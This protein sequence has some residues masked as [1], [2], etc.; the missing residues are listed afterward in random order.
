MKKRIPSFFSGF[1]TA[2]L[3]LALTTTALAASGKVRYNFANVALDGETK[4]AAGADITAANGQQIPGSILYTD[5]SGGKTNY[6]PI[7][8]ISGLLGVE[9]GYDSA[10]KTVLLGRQSGGAPAAQACWN[11]TVD[12]NRVAY[13]CA[14]T[15]GGH[16]AAPLYRPTWQAEGW[17]LESLATDG[18]GA[19]FAAWRYLNGDGAIISLTCA[20]PVGGSFGFQPG[21]EDS[22]KNCRQVTVQGCRADL[23]MDI[24]SCYL[25]WENSDGVLFTM[26][27]PD[28][29]TLRQVAESIRPCAKEA[30]EYQPSWLPEG[31][32]QLE[33]SVLGDTAYASWIGSGLS[34]TWMQ[35]AAPLALPEGTPETVSVNGVKARYWAAERPY[36]KSPVTVNG[37]PLEEDTTSLGG[38]T[39][40]SGVVHGVQSEDMSTLAW[41]SGGV[42]FRLQGALDRETLVRIAE[43]VTLKK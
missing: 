18:R 34:L 43:G 21:L 25:A 39:I 14:E 15:D 24:E 31:Y 32:K 20:N 12:G 37:E 23:Y 13:T 26:R 17:G 6:L 1:L 41:S 35:T 10:T 40:T 22:V 5:A 29:E 16:D 36:E 9:I 11:R 3:L 27:G 28:A 38:V 19:A 33:R 8:T 30:P 42:N 2:V 7:R 4:I